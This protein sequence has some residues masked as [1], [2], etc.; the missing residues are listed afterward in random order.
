MPAGFRGGRGGPSIFIP[1]G[2][3]VGFG[4]QT[5]A[6]QAV[7]GPTTRSS[8]AP[9]RRKRRKKTNVARRKSAPVRKRRR[10]VRGKASRMVKGSAA[11]KRHMARLRKM[12]KR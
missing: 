11:A 5:P 1:P 9:G 7:L 4:S 10:A 6:T 12:R 2:G 3:F 8:G